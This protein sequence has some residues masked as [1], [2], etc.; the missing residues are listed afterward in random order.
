MLPP[1]FKIFLKETKK[2]NLIYQSSN[3]LLGM[4]SGKGFNLIGKTLEE[5]RHE[6]LIEKMNE[7]RVV[8]EKQ[9][10]ENIYREI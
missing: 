5:I 9:K 2:K 1:N 6:L 8:D 4:D 10:N 3:K 7:Q